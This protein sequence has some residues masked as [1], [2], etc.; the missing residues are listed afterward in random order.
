MSSKLRV[1]VT[2]VHPGDV[3][4]RL[5][6]IAEVMLIEEPD[7]GDPVR[8]RELSSGCDAVLSISGDRLDS[9]FFQA[10][11]ERL[12]IVAQ[13]AVGYDNIDVG[14]AER[15][16]VVVTNTPDV[17]TDATADLTLG[18]MLALTRR[19]TD[20][21]RLIRDH[22]PWRLAPTFM[23]GSQLG[24]RSLGIVGLGRIGQA[25]ARRAV[26]FG[27]KIAYS[28]SN[29]EPTAAARA[30]GATPK[31]LESL[32]AES[33]VISLHC[34]LSPSTRHLIGQREFS[35]MPATSFLINAARGPVVDEEALVRALHE[36]QIAGAALDVFEH[37]PAVHPGLLDVGN[38]V[39]TPHLGSATSETRT[40]MAQLA[41]D[42]IIAIL[43]SQ[44]PLTP[45]TRA[46]S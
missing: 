35:I 31:P 24:G 27:M 28:S 32:L 8:L 23:L 13:A 18:L 25:V 41:A 19:I 29:V 43:R 26:A 15:R 36:E 16:G 6:D 14:A 5:G 34:P 38:V 12:Q 10:A 45:V 1:L 42:N 21:D 2:E 30:I 4:G 9:T 33:D 17:L 40:A 22:V 20:G 37:E 39:M 46:A 11:D 7:R 44:A 3:A